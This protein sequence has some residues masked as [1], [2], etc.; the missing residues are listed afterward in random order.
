[1]LIYNVEEEKYKVFIYRF[2]YARR[3]WINI[4]TND[5]AEE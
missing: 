1:M 3:D 4:L 2:M 5:L